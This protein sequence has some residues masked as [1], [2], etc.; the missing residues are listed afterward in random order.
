ML[1]KSNLKLF[2]NYKVFPRF[3]TSFQQVLQYLNITYC[4]KNYNI[5]VVCFGIETVNQVKNKDAFKSTDNE[6]LILENKILTHIMRKKFLLSGT[7]ELKINLTKKKI[8][9]QQFN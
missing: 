5:K 6:E 1:D 4:V 3:L 9:Q 8:L 2:T 7:R